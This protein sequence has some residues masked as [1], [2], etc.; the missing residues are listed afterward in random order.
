M[1][2]HSTQDAAAIAASF[3]KVLNRHGYPFQYC[4]LRRAH[5]LANGARSKWIFEATE[6]PV[7]TQETGTRIDFVLKL[8]RDRSATLLAECKRVNPRM[9][10]WCFVRAPYSRRTARVPQLI[11]EEVSQQPPNGHPQVTGPWGSVVSGARKIA[12]AAEDV[13]HVGLVIEGP[14]TGDKDGKPDRDAIEVAATQICRGLNGFVNLLSAKTQLLGSRHCAVLLPVIFTTAKLWAADVDLGSPEG[15]VQIPES[16][17]KAKNWLWYEYNQSPGIRHAISSDE[18]PGDLN[19]MLEH[20]FV[21]SI[22]IVSLDGVDEFLW[23]S[24]EN[25]DT[26]M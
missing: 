19:A 14:E 24:G 13:F 4:I 18:Q 11:L 2:S 12:A 26:W 9:S 8:G 6:V 1:V 16:Q 20:D 15:H 25:A 17:L 3:E 7:Q 23:W 5:E 22:A 21:R 10:N